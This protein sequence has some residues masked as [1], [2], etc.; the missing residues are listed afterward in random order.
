MVKNH[1]E[2]SYWPHMI[3]GF[4]VVGVTLSYWTVKSASSLPV[5]ESNEY[6]MKYQ[7]ADMHINTILAHKALFDAKYAIQIEAETAIRKIENSKA[8]QEQRSVVL[9]KGENRFIYHVTKRSDTEPV[10]DA[11]VTFLL[12]R[13]H[14]TE[15]D[16]LIE[17]IPMQGE[18]YVVKEVNISKP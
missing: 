15:D 13:P 6:M 8:F 14:T 1:K 10:K 2:K 4:L 7:K 16:Q 5:Q 3:L 9:H 12:T 18:R 17:E 11:N